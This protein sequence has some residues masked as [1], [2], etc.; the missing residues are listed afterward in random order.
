MKKKNVLMMALSLALVAVIAV[1]GTLA[2]L[3]D[4]TGTMTNTFTFGKLQV[5][6]KETA[7]GVAV[8]DGSGHDYENLLPGATVQ[9]DVKIKLVDNK[10]KAYVYVAVKNDNSTAVQYGNGEGDGFKAGVTNDWKPV[11]AT[12]P[13]IADYDLYVYTGGQADAKAVETFD[14]TTL[15]ANAKVKEYSNNETMTTTTIKIASYA[16]QADQMGDTN[17]DNK[18]AEYFNGYFN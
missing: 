8:S 4:N 13:A 2:Y 12:E 3:T 15:F 17:F 7:D 11:T 10:T 6:Q 1:G 5:E 14:F 16:I 9:K 18:A